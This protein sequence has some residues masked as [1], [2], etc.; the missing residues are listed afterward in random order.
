MRA[1]SGVLSIVLWALSFSVPFVVAAIASPRD[2]SKLTPVCLWG[3]SC[4]LMMLLATVNLVN[5][6]W[7]PDH[8][9]FVV[10]WKSTAVG[11]GGLSMYRSVRTLT[12]WMVRADTERCAEQI[13]LALARVHRPSHAE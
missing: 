6:Q 9:G 8:T 2:G 7:I 11:V 1:L 3:V 13:Q 4:G 12:A 5:A 10:L